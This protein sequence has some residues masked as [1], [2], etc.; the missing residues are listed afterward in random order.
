[1]PI[2]HRPVRWLLGPLLA[3][4]VTLP[5]ED[6]VAQGSGVTP[7]VIGTVLSS[8]DAFRKTTELLRRTYE[9]TAETINRSG[10][11][12]IGGKVVPVRIEHYQDGSA[13]ELLAR[14]YGRM[15]DDGVQIF[16]G[17]FGEEL[18]RAAVR[19][20][21]ERGL[22]LVLPGAPPDQA[23]GA[24]SLTVF[25]TLPMAEE[26]PRALFDYLAVARIRP[27]RIGLL[28]SQDA[29]GRSVADAVA[30]EVAGDGGVSLERIPFPVGLPDV[31]AVLRPLG[32]PLPDWVLVVGRREENS[33]LARR[34]RGLAGSSTVVCAV[35]GL[36]AG[37]IE[38]NKKG[39]MDGIL[40]LDFWN[41][42]RHPGDEDLGPAGAFV[43]EFRKKFGQDPDYHAA[44]AAMA[45][46][47]IQRGIEAAGDTRAD[48]VAE[49]IA[50]LDEDLVFW[51]AAFSREGRMRGGGFLGVVRR[52]RVE[53]LWPASSGG[54]AT[55][56]AA[57]RP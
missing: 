50:G 37:D 53:P 27:S 5:A 14:T 35:G 33:L 57:A 32:K 28:H 43:R 40:V 8:H 30:R 52:T 41:S 31:E 39:E 21:R 34:I 44:A 10:G 17:P 23:G 55:P 54:G 16:L 36:P 29:F 26:L 18:T 20:A 19:A 22:L 4:A 38:K 47:V 25:S 51:R 11:V 49:S 45:L 15:A 24:P 1:M 56:P 12:R 42:R 2:C 6:I 46:L 13:P 9:F 48:R 3:L 7:V